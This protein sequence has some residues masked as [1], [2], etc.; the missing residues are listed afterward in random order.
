MNNREID[1]GSAEKLALYKHGKMCI[2][3]V[4]VYTHDSLLQKITIVRELYYSIVFFV[5]ADRRHNTALG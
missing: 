2:Q 4:I 5:S 1:Y 3:G